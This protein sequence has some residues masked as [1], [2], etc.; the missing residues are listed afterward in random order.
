MQLEEIKKEIK[1][2]LNKKYIEGKKNE[3]KKE[4]EK[5]VVIS[6]EEFKKMRYID[7]LNLKVKSTKTVD[8]KIE[9]TKELVKK[10]K[11]FKTILDV[12]SQLKNELEEKTRSIKDKLASEIVRDWDTPLQDNFAEVVSDYKN[13][14]NEIK[15]KVKKLEEKHNNIAREKT[16]KMLE[17]LDKVNQVLND[18]DLIKYEKLELKLEKTDVYPISHFNRDLEEFVDLLKEGY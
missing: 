3:K 17:M 11:E 10:D 9:Q 12:E 14:S 5:T 6:Q 7:R 8:E 15:E 4:N 13:L 18:D 2:E 16:G 1:E